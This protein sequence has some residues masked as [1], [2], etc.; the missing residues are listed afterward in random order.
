MAFGA[1]IADL[2][3]PLVA[4]PRHPGP[5]ERGAQRG[6]RSPGVG[7]D[8]DGDGVRAAEVAAVDV[9]LDD[10]RRRLDVAVVVE[11]REVAEPRADDEQDVGAAARRG[12]LGR[13]GATERAHVERVVVGH[14]V[15]AAVGGDGRPA[16][17][18]AQLSHQVVGAG[19]RHA[20]ADQHQR[21][22]RGAQHAD[23]VGNRLGAR[24]RGVQRTI[25]GRLAKLRGHGL[26][27]EDVARD[28]DEH[29]ALA[30][31]HRGAQREAEEFGDAL[32]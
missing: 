15:V 11:R 29:R 17:I 14:G 4:G 24:R 27:V 1:E 9:D 8:R 12:S 13:A 16:E 6:E 7:L 2:V 18:G 25:A 21:P 5:A 19:P 30:P 26:V 23:G 32:G 28:V 31:G 20:T 10:T 3:A 22:A